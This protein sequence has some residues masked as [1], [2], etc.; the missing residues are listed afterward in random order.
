MLLRRITQHVRDQNWIAIVLDFVIVVAGVFVGIQVAN[1]K[2]QGLRNAAVLFYTWPGIEDAIDEGS[3]SLY[4]S[5]FRGILPV[6][7]QDALTQ[8]CGDRLSYSE[9]V[10]QPLPLLRLRAMNLRTSISNLTDAALGIS[11]GLRPIVEETS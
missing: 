9:S 3:T 4:R 5:A 2:D 10:G 8:H 7:V 1:W 6:E 11:E